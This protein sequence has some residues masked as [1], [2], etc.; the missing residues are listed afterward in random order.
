MGAKEVEDVV[1][2]VRGMAGGEPRMAFAINVDE[3]LQGE[4]RVMMLAAGLTEPLLEPE[5]DMLPVFNERKPAASATTE[6]LYRPERLARHAVP[7]V[8]E[9]SLLKEGQE[10]AQY[11]PAYMRRPGKNG[12]PQG[13]G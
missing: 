12:S 7:A 6:S 13:R 11:L 4:M 1:Q 8:P 9:P 2:Q 3:A 5:P 10:K